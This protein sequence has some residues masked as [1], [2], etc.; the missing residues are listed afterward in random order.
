[1]MQ[2]GFTKMI[3]ATGH[4]RQALDGIYVSPLKETGSTLPSS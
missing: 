4:C 3:S 1:M 2:T